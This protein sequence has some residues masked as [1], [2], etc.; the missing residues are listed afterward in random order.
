MLNASLHCTR[1][2]WCDMASRSRNTRSKASRAQVVSP[3]EPVS[4]K[5]KHLDRDPVK[6]ESNDGKQQIEGQQKSSK[7]KQAGPYEDLERPTPAEC[8]VLLLSC[9]GVHVDLRERCS[10][11]DTVC[12]VC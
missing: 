7:K 11:S 9:A 4:R 3:A 8:Q 12:V 2:A 6:T 10:R 1:E 5:R